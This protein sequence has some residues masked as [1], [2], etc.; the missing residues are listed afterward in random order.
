[1]GEFSVVDGTESRVCFL[2]LRA[3]TSSTERDIIMHVSGVRSVTNA[4]STGHGVLA[5]LVSA[6]GAILIH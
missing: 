1:M 3:C 4:Q 6:S 5:L 2:V